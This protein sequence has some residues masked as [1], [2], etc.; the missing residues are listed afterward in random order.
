MSRNALFGVARRVT[1]VAA[2]VAATASW[3]VSAQAQERGRGGGM[4]GGRGGGQLKSSLLTIE[5]VQQELKLT[6]EQIE[7]VVAKAE[8]LNEKMRSEMRALREDEAGED[9]MNELMNELRD[10]DKTIVA[11]LNDEQN[12]RLTQLWFQRMGVA[13]YQNEE[14][15]AAIELTDDQ[16]AKVEEIFASGREKMQEAMREAEESGDRE[17]IRETMQTLMTE[18]EE[19]LAEILTDEQKEKLEEVK[20]APFEFP[21]RQ[22]GGG[23]RQRSDF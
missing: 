3:C 20:G 2:V 12:A 22:R 7:G 15:Q 16:K 23:G 10:E 6:D 18:Q 5:E 21:R 19:S 11:E 14:F 4:F 1:V 17:G 13:A 9:E 8:A